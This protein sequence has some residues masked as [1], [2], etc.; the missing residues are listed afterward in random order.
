M[1]QRI[2]A[3]LALLLLVPVP[4]LGILAVLVFFPGPTGRMLFSMAKVWL[5]LF[6]ALWYLSVEKGRLS[7]SPLRHGGTGAGL[8]LGV[9]MAATV[10]AATWFFAAGHIDP[11]ELRLRVEGMG[12]ASPARYLGAAT[13]WIF[14]NSVIEEYVFRWFIGRQCEELTGKKV[15]AAL[16]S[17][18]FFT[19]HHSIAMAC[20][21]ST[22][23][24]ALASAG[25]FAAG[26][27]WSLLYLRY[28]SIW[29]AWTAHALADIAVFAAG[30]FLLFAG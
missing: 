11:S 28:R 4:S 23:L 3:S 16:L 2:R 7:L 18:L 25:V 14:I 5:L 6:P 12:I 1:T 30:W 29:P 21:L 26:F 20:Y 17:A 24:V 27:I 10:L 13:Y 22:G 15:P 9:F 8:L 19:V